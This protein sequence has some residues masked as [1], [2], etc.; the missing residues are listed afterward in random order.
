MKAYR[1]ALRRYFEWLWS[2]KRQGREQEEASKE[3]ET[4]FYL[5]RYLSHLATVTSGEYVL[6]TWRILRA[7][8]QKDLPVQ[9]TEVLE[10]R[11]Q[12]LRRDANVRHPV[13]YRAADAIRLKDLN[14][15]MAQLQ[16]VKLS[17]GEQTAVEILCV[18]FATMS[19]VAE[20][21]A[22]TV[23]D[24]FDGGRTISIR[25]K[26]QARTCKRQ[27]KRVTDIGFIR[28]ATFVE[29]RRNTAIRKGRRILFSSRRNADSPISSSAVSGLLKKIMKKIRSTRR[30]TAHSA[31]KG[32]AVEALLSGLPVVTIQSFG[33]WQDMGTLER[34]LGDSL[35][36]NVAWVDL[37]RT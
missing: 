12:I 3:E 22:L 35:R 21:S 6:R 34:Y 37:L 8:F 1:E 23:D 30:V 10:Q 27:V 28:A 7:V 33:G 11:V 26:T 31:R 5:G 2:F 19:R 25:P 20:I 32:A 17:Y 18:A 24:V 36:R 16:Y 14:D 4:G 29:Q 9:E 15:L 13:K